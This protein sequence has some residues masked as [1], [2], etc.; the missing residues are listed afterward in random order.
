[1][2]KDV[3]K[4]R[5]IPGFPG[6]MISKRGV[7]YSSLR[8]NEWRRLKVHVTNKGRRKA[9]LY[10]EG[11]R[12]SI[13]L[14]RLVALAWVNNPYN[15][16]FVLHNDNDPMND[17]HKNLRWGTQQ[18]NIQQCM[19]QGRHD[20]RVL[21]SKQSHKILKLYNNGVFNIRGKWSKWAKKFNCSRMTLKRAIER[22]L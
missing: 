20:K 15:L 19:D 21:T 16:P 6:Y 1:M 10:I 13:G 8:G 2:S 12:V 11:K 9:T 14:N 3:S 17:Y 18:Q 4:L 7:L 22:S 5:H